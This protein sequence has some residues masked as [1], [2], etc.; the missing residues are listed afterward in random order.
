MRCAAITSAGARCKLE[1]THGSYCYQHAPEMAEER[2]RRASKGGRTGGNG[3]GGQSEMAE[4]KRE[5]RRV[6]EAVDSGETERGVGAVLFQGFNTL[7]KA[8]ET[9]RRIAEQEEVLE[10]IAALEEST[11]G[12]ARWRA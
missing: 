11:T 3:R 1:A 10:R 4:L 2:K 6:I 9:E 12:G 7:L 8:V 5:I